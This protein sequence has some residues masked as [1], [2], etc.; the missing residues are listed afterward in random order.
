MRWTS[1]Q[2]APPA[3]TPLQTASYSA[4]TGMYSFKDRHR[5]LLFGAHRRLWHLD[6]D[7]PDASGEWSATSAS[8]PGSR[9]TPPGGLPRSQTK[10]EALVN[11]FQPITG[12]LDVDYAD[13]SLYTPFSTNAAT[14]LI[15]SFVGGIAGRP[16]IHFTLNLVMPAAFFESGSTPKV[17]GPGIVTVSYPFTALD[18]GTNGALQALF[19][20]TDTTI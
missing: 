7:D 12:Q 15:I 13:N 1:P 16:S 10:A 18:D 2:S 3:L 14:G 8:R 9:K 5:L 6:T 17:T 20:S 11:N 4:S 19:I